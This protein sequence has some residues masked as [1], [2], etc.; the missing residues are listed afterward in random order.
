MSAMRIRNFVVL[1]KR[2]TSGDPMSHYVVSR[3]L[4]SLKRCSSFQNLIFFIKRFVGTRKRTT[5]T[6]DKRT[7]GRNLAPNISVWY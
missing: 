2:S 1:R 4:V 7:L 3:F 5:E 6:T